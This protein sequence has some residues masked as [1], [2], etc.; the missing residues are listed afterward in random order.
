M[1]KQIIKITTVVENK[2]AVPG[3]VEE[4]GLAFWVEVGSHRILFDTGQGGALLHNARALSVDL[5]TADAIALSHG[6]YDHTGG[7]PDF[8]RVNN[9]AC[10]YAH[11][12]AFAP[13]YSR[14]SNSTVHYAGMPQSDDPKFVSGVKRAVL[15]KLPTEIFPGIGL[16]GEIPRETDFEDTG[17]AFFLDEDCRTPDT[18]LDDQAMFFSSSC[19]T[20]VV[21]GCAHAG[22][23]NTLRYIR[24]LTENRHIHVV[25]GGTHLIRASALRLD[26]TIAYLR[27]IGVDRVAACH[28]TGPK[29]IARLAADLPGRCF[30]CAAGESIAF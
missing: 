2:A 14:G 12:A 11:P 10:R 19:G 9:N 16:T 4:H 3:L 17:G 24:S 26:A 7:M 25:M 23:V 30:S 1:N 8:F 5:A 27:E 18:L 13:K 15:T 6:H 22:L 29:A 21:L 20:I 28:C